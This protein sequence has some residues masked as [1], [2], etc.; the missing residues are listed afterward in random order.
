HLGL[1]G[2]RPGEEGG[3]RVLRR[4]G[5]DDADRGRPAR[6][7]SPRRTGL[8]GGSRLGREELAAEGDA[9]DLDAVPLAGRGATWVPGSRFLTRAPEV[10]YR[11]RTVFDYVEYRS[12]TVASRE[13]RG[14]ARGS[15]PLGREEV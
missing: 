15:S 1:V 3:A 7:R 10:F 5:R 6:R 13:S 14:T 8:E 11:R 12:Q 2:H 9:Y 4:P